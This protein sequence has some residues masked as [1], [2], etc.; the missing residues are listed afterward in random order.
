MRLKKY[1]IPKYD[2]YDSADQKALTQGR[3]YKILAFLNLSRFGATKTSS[4][5]VVCNDLGNELNYRVAEFELFTEA[6]YQDYL[7]EL[8]L[9]T[10]F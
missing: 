3:T 1:A 8:L 9:K 6:E 7:D 4:N 2:I 10:E 5:I